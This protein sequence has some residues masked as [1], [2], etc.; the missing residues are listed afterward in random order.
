MTNAQ[1]IINNMVTAGLDPME[2]VVDTFAGWK[3]RGYIV[4]KG[5]TAVFKTKIWKP[6][7]A[8][9]DTEETEDTTNLKLVN[10]AFFTAEQVK[11]IG[12]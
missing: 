11:A 6:C 2:T 10:A 5:E 12:A 7:K 1:I 4:N 8:K 3:R 9:K